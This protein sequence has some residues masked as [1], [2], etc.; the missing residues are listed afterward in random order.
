MEETRPNL[1]LEQQALLAVRQMRRKLEAME[2]ERNA[3]IAIVGLA[4]RFPGEADS[5][6][7]YT[8]LLLENG[9][10]VVDIPQ[11]R[12]DVASIFNPD[13][14]VPGKTYCRA[15]GL[16]RDPARFDADFFG[17]S[18][19]EALSMDPQQRLLLEVSW[20]ALERAGLNPAALTGADYG[21]F[22]GL[23]T[24]EYAQRYA[25][26]VAPA[27][28]SAHMVGGSA[29][30]AAA[31]RLS[32]TLG[33]HG[34]SMVIDT[35]CSSSLVA[36][37]RACRSLRDGECQLALAGGAN[38]MAVRESLITAS[39]AGMLA[40]DGRLKAFDKAADGFIR[41]EG[42]G[43][44]VLKRLRDAEA[45]GD[46]IWA[47]IRGSAVNQD[48][49]S[50]GLTVPNG[51]AQQALL[52]R[53]LANA[54]IAPGQVGYVEA[55]GTGTALGDPIEAE[56]LGQVYG[57][58]RSA[59]HPL[60]IGSV[61]TNLGHLEAAAGIASLIK[62]VVGL[63]SATMPGQLHWHEPSPHIRWD[64]L[65]V[66]VV[67]QSRE[68]PAIDGRRLAG[69]SAFGFSGTNAHVIVEEAPAVAQVTPGAASYPR[70]FHLLTITAKSA[71]ALTRLTAR[72]VDFLDSAGADLPWAE[73][74]HTA[75]VAR[76]H[77]NHRLSVRARSVEEGLSALR[78]HGRGEPVDSVVVSEA[79]AAARPRVAF[80]L[81]TLEDTRVREELTAWPAFR[82]AYSHCGVSAPEPFARLYAL[83][84]LWRSWGVLPRA[85]AGT[86]DGT[87]V[88]AVLEGAVPLEEA[89]AR[90]RAGERRPSQATAEFERYPV[91]L[92]IG[93]TEPGIPALRPD[94][95]VM[96][97]LTA[98]VQLIDAAGVD[99]D[100]KAWNEGLGNRRVD[101]PTY[102]FTEQ[103][104]WIEPVPET[105]SRRQ[106]AARTTHHPLLGVELRSALETV[107]FESQLSGAEDP[108]WLELHRVKG[109]AVM[110]GAGLIEMLLAAAHETAAA[111][112]GPDLALE[113]LVFVE[114]LTWDH[115]QQRPIVQVLVDGAPGEQQRIRVMSLAPPAKPEQSER[116]RSAPPKLAPP[117]LVSDTSF[118]DVNFERSEES[119]SAWRLH[120]EARL[121]AQ[122]EPA[123][124]DSL[125]QRRV[126][127]TEEVD[128]DE[129]YARLESLGMEFGPQ[130]RGLA[131]LWRG[132]GEALG[133]VQAEHDAGSGWLLYPPLLDGCLQVAAAA[134]LDRESTSGEALYLPFQVGRLHV[135]APL[136]STVFSHVQV[137]STDPHAPSCNLSLFSADGRL[138]A[139]FYRLIFHAVHSAA[140]DR[141]TVSQT[142]AL[143]HTAWIE[144]DLPGKETPLATGNWIIFADRGGLGKEL[145]TTLEREHCTYS[146]VSSG[147]RFA[148]TGTNEWAV[149]PGEPADYARLLAELPAAQGVLHLWTLDASPLTDLNPAGLMQLQ[150]LGYG[151]ALL[152]TKA[153]LADARHSGARLA[154]VTRGANAV[155]NAREATSAV[156]PALW[157]L[158][159][160]LAA[161]HPE[162]RASSID[163]DPAD[164]SHSLPGLL[165]ALRQTDEPEVAVRARYFYVPRLKPIEEQAA[166]SG[167]KRVELVPSASGLI[168]DL[169]YRHVPREAPADDEVEIQ[170][171][172]TGLN[173]RDVLHVFAML[174][175]SRPAIGGECAGI[176]VR[177]G[178]DSGLTPGREVFA[179]A[180]GWFSSYATIPARYVALKPAELT[181]EQAA[182]LP[183]AYMT[184]IFGLRRLA[185]LKRGQTVLIHSAAG[186]LGLAAVRIAQIAGA[187]IY[188]TAGSDKKRRFLRSLGVKHVFASRDLE[189][190][191][192]IREL[193]K[194]AG[195]DVVLNSLSGEFIEKSLALV[196]HN[197]CFLEVGKR[198]ILQRQDA[199]RLRPD[200]LYHAFD[201]GEEANRDEGFIPSLLDELL[202]GLTD[203][204]LEPL[205]TSIVAF[206]NARQ[207]FRMMAAAQHT[208]KIIVRHDPSAVAAGALRAD[209]KATYLITGGLGALGRQTAGWLIERGARHLILVSRTGPT[210]EIDGIIQDWALLG[211]SISVAKADCADAARM[212]EIVRSIDPAY[213]LRGVIHAAG[214][215]DDSV[216]EK[217]SPASFSTVAGP[218]AQGAWVLHDVTLECPLQFFVIYSSAAAVLGSPG[219][220]NYA[221][222]NALADALAHYRHSLGLPALAVNWGPWA[223][224]GMLANVKSGGRDGGFHR[225]AASEAFA[226]LDEL[227]RTGSAQGCILAGHDWR[228]YFEE[229]IAERSQPFFNLLR[230]TPPRMSRSPRG[231]SATG[232]SF[233]ELLEREA[234]ASRRALVLHLVNAHAIGVLGLEGQRQL[235]EATPLH[236]LG[237]D[238]LLAVELRNSLSKTVGRPLPASLLFDYPSP[239]ALADY[240]HT[241]ALPAAPASPVPSVDELSS[242]SDEA[243]EALLLAE[244]NTA[245]HVLPR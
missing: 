35:A 132:T 76:A 200:V 143:Y 237:L 69:V 28:F 151:S 30:N 207:A 162:W 209:A 206:A 40:H 37:D 77:W 149:H 80:L 170:V 193:T 198:G 2:Q 220:A 231:G 3:P 232:L 137:T 16:L 111:D 222:A 190:A 52:R 26:S 63:R 145:A 89:V 214:V 235:D 230:T 184:A 225:M 147:A 71:E 119:A 188:A 120:V 208:G 106:I 224:A 204:S 174:P 197:G 182:G 245:S 70:D 179:F 73:I 103:R 55:H 116:D 169:Q 105:A 191:K 91:H 238:S 15:A 131:Q 176:V 127:C 129:F 25:Q 22:V 104:Y 7:G 14:D 216:L 1:T 139:Q 148:Q 217:Q 155:W 158:R 134:L 24:W 90:V 192:G 86:G 64:E 66:R 43:V 102:P 75:N 125:E 87:W 59:D 153:L 164:R 234:P 38:I 165:A 172:A 177:A 49:P 211:A 54:G 68:W 107:Q 117:K 146:L 210:P 33:W 123:V 45:A 48:G 178:K 221:A 130:F 159:R 194:G 34:P 47:V 171:F 101:L 186:G 18:P 181:F 29:L 199:A 50:S 133:Q 226:A 195:V 67:T 241:A 93:G 62:V 187:T 9:N 41:G 46:R 121:G 213:P 27:D 136:E 124:E 72:Y 31:G 156:G 180:P 92:V 8:K 113:D 53:A 218:K 219:Q 19:R 138:L 157:S 215:L 39:K 135:Y 60:W 212:T 5:L 112:A 223:G 21:V 236:E 175:Q 85:L 36:V 166:A 126:R 163:L 57:E 12:F 109:H 100:W 240:L 6:A 58:G 202:R 4:C 95:S 32:Y 154:L 97:A 141:A 205:P 74:C 233:V 96:E 82:D 173:F 183:I 244:L 201:L 114:P 115:P 242:L 44:V 83:T 42:C 161:E 94:L 227:A 128:R 122:Q 144:A 11:S 150:T 185:R 196:K 20:E 167:K 65:P 243:A 152:L 110:A 81:G 99:I 118:R 10:A 239:G 203:H 168:E 142:T 13:P 51:L 160:T 79:A 108:G 78:A 84:E 229:H 228:R 98:A 88:A 189:F 56:A 17:I 140:T 23:T 61:K